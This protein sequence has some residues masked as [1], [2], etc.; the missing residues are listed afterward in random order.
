[1]GYS[2]IWAQKYFKGIEYDIAVKIIIIPMVEFI[3]KYILE[4]NVFSQDSARD[5]RTH[6]ALTFLASWY[7]TPFTRK[8]S[9]IAISFSIV[10]IVTI[11]IKVCT[12]TGCSRT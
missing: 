4:Y 9:S 7:F 3:L 11:V 8:T 2:H 10:T 6:T 12:N 1:M 5:D